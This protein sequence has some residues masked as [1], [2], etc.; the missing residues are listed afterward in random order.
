MFLIWWLS[1]KLVYQKAG[2]LVFQQITIRC[3]QRFFGNLF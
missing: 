2:I 1:G 3:S